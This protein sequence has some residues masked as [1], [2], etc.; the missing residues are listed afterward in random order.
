ML[1]INDQWITSNMEQKITEAATIHSIVEYTMGKYN[2]TKTVYDS[3]DWEAIKQGRKGYSKRYNIRITKLIFDWVN[4]G[5]Q[6][7][8]I[9]Q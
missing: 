2:W 1:K 6:K 3:I 4:T 9:N 7:A 5:H 8:K